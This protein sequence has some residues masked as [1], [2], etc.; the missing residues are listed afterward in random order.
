MTKIKRILLRIPEYISKRLQVEAK[1]QDRS[2]NKIIVIALE[3][4]FKGK[5]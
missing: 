1:K 2:V 4:F 5:K 3:K